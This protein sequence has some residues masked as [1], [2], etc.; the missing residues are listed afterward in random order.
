MGYGAG[1]KRYRIWSP[2]ECKVILSRSV[3]F[4]ENSILHSSVESSVLG[5]SDSAVKQVEFEITLNQKD[6]ED[7]P[8][9]HEST[10]SCTELKKKETGASAAASRARSTSGG[11]SR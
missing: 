5:S 4:N 10:L 2:S 3:T 6:V 1:V 9:S 8:Q 7:S 11:A